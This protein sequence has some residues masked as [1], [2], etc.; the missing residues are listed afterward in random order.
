MKRIVAAFVLLWMTAASAAE[1]QCQKAA[2]RDAR[3]VFW[4]WRE[5]DG[6]GCWFIRPR[7]GM[8][9][10]SA[11]TWTKEEPEEKPAEASLSEDVSPAP[12]QTK[13]EPSIRVR[14]LKVKPI[15][16]EEAAQV[17]ANWL[18]ELPEK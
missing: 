1:I 14:L 17:R 5:I 13:P 11:F 3:G 18:T 8:P 9:P 7:G 2:G 12:E 16:P 10:K 4:S 6:K 15:T